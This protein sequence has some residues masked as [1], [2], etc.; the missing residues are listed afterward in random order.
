MGNWIFLAYFHILN[1][2]HFYFP[3]CK[4]RSIK[5]FYSSSVLTMHIS[6][7]SSALFSTALPT[8]Q[9]SIINDWIKAFIITPVEKVK[10]PF[11]N[12]HLLPLHNI[13]GYYLVFIVPAYLRLTYCMVVLIHDMINI[14]F[15]YN[16]FSI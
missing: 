9:K 10:D 16:S 15:Q 6:S 7:D 3:F 13:L 11:L 4:S 12:K 2:L 14:S 5:V 8:S 1:Y